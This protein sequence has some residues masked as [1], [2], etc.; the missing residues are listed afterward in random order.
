[1]PYLCRVIDSSRQKRRDVSPKSRVEN[2]GY[3]DREGRV[4]GGSKGKAQRA[5]RAAPA[6]CRS[7]LVGDDLASD[8]DCVIEQRRRKPDFSSPQDSSPPWWGRWDSN[9]RHPPSLSST[10]IFT[11]SRISSSLHLGRYILL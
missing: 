1:M 2:S 3:E 8:Q 4:H 5:R 11:R 9:P 10:G 7:P 6:T